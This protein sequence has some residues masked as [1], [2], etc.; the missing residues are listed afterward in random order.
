MQYILIF[1]SSSFVISNIMTLALVFGG[2]SGVPWIIRISTSSPLL[3][4]D[5]TLPTQVRPTANA[6]CILE[7]GVTKHANHDKKVHEG[8]ECVLLFPDHSEVVNLAQPMNL[9]WLSV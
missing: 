9:S 6:H 3:H 7:K 2:L 1:T 5:S 8:L 4:N